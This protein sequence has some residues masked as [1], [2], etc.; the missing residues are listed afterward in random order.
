MTVYKLDQGANISM[1]SL[2]GTLKATFPQMIEKFGEGLKGDYKVS[3]EWSFTD[4]EDNVFT[5]YDWKSTK[6]YASELDLPEPE[7]LW[8]SNEVYEFHVGGRSRADGFVEWISGELD[9][10]DSQQTF[11]VEWTEKHRTR[12][13]AL[14]GESALEGFIESDLVE[15]EHGYPM[16]T[17]CEII[18]INLTNETHKIDEG[19]IAE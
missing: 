8:N 3:M 2:K 15:E 18:N 4:D 12:V 1:T 7:E 19:F 14:N 10:E 5:V 16:M 6:L 13:R 11:I 9:L 17:F